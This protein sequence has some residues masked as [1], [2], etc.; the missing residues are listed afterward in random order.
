VRPYHPGRRAVECSE[1][2]KL[3]FV[4]HRYTRLH[5]NPMTA[6]SS[7]TDHRA[8]ALDLAPPSRWRRICPS[9]LRTLVW[10]DGA[11]KYD[12]FLSYSWKCDRDI[13]PVIQSLLQNFL[14]PRYKIRAKTV[15]RDL[16]SLPAGSSLEAELF[17]RLDHSEHL[18]ILASPDAAT[19]RGM[20]IE[21]SHWFSRERSGEVLIVVTAGNDRDWHMIRDHLVPPSIRA[22]LTEP[23]LASIKDLRDQI[24][25]TAKKARPVLIGAL[26]EQLKQ[27]IL[28]FYPERDWGQLRGEERRLRQRAISLLI[29]AAMLFLALATAAGGFAWYAERERVI[30]ES[31]AFSAESEQDL[32]QDRP[33]ALHRAIA[34]RNTKRLPEA[35]LA[36][37][38]SLPQLRGWLE[39]HTGAVRSVAVSA[40]GQTVLTAGADVTA[41]LWKSD[42]GQLLISSRSP[43]TRSDQSEPTF[44]GIRPTDVPSFRA[45]QIVGARFALFVS[46]AHVK[47]RLKQGDGVFES[48]LENASSSVVLPVFSNLQS[49]IVGVRGGFRAPSA[50]SMQLSVEPGSHAL[51]YDKF[52]ERDFRRGG[53][54]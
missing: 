38:D 24:L 43:H 44:A 50:S 30:A 40:D 34:T 49:V 28:R 17:D 15:F 48:G 19:S 37:A 6:K 52:E 12:A 3:V 32:A 54:E 53:E 20:E 46:L 33:Q 22:N 27:V 21:A 39:G 51:E 42:T 36:V 45:A 2:T 25:T 14:R 47:D 41:R 35:R 11:S 31:R 13:A 26:T 18:I 23:V 10:V 8:D 4:A 5:S 7:G 16:S 29:G 1:R 9:W